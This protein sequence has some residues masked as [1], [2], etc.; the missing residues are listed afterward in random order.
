MEGHKLCQYWEFYLRVPAQQTKKK[1]AALGTFL[2]LYSYTSTIYHQGGRV[3]EEECEVTMNCSEM[4]RVTNILIG[5]FMRE[6]HACASS[7]SDDEDTSRLQEYMLQGHGGAILRLLI[8]T[9]V[10]GLSCGCDLADLLAS[11]LHWCTNFPITQPTELSLEDLPNIG[12]CFSHLNKLPTGQQNRKLSRP[13]GYSESNK[14]SRVKVINTKGG[15]V[16]QYASS[17][18][19]D[20]DDPAMEPPTDPLLSSSSLPRPS[21]QIFF[22]R[23]LSS[24]DEGEE[25]SEP[26]NE[27]IQNVSLSTNA[28]SLCTLMTRLL[29]ELV[30]CDSRSLRASNMSERLLPQIVELYV[31]LNEPMDVKC[32]PQGWTDQHVLVLKQYLLRTVF[33][34]AGCVCTLN[35]AVNTLMSCTPGGIIQT[36]LMIAQNV[37]KSHDSLLVSY[38]QDI[39]LGT[40]TIIQTSFL[41]LPCNLQC[42]SETLNL[43]KEF[44]FQHRGYNVFTSVVQALVDEIRL[45]VKSQDSQVKKRR[46]TSLIEKIG[47]IILVM[48]NIKME[49]IHSMKCSKSK[50]RKCDFSEYKNHHHDAL[51]IKNVVDGTYSD[52]YGTIDAF[53][54]FKEKSLLKQDTECAVNVIVKF[55]FNFYCAIENKCIKH[56]IIQCILKHGIC[57]CVHPNDVIGTL[58]HSIDT[59]DSNYRTQVLSLV[60]KLILEQC[61]GSDISSLTFK[62][63]AVCSH[64]TS[65]NNGSNYQSHL[66]DASD[67]ALSSSESL[68]E[69][70]DLTGTT[71]WKCIKVLQKYLTHRKES[72]GIDVSLLLLRLSMNGG[73][74]LKKQL[75]QSVYMP[76]LKLAHQT[77]SPKPET[78]TEGGP[79]HQA[80][81]QHILAGFPPLLKVLSIQQ[82]FLDMGGAE[83]LSEMVNQS[84]ISQA[85]LHILEV[86]VVVSGSDAG[87][88]HNSILNPRVSDDS[89]EIGFPDSPYEDDISD[90]GGTASSLVIC[91]VLD[92]ILGSQSPCTS[93]NIWRTCKR[94]ANMSEAFVSQF[95]Q[96]QGFDVA[97]RLLDE[98]LR[99]YID[100]DLVEDETV[101]ELGTSDKTIVGS[102]HS[103]VDNVQVDSVHPTALQPDCVQLCLLESLLG[104]VLRCAEAPVPTGLHVVEKA[105]VFSKLSAYLE[106][107][108]HQSSHN[109]KLLC[110]CLLS[111]AVASDTPSSMVNFGFTTCRKG[112]GDEGT[113]ST[114][115]ISSESESEGHTFEH[116]Y[117]ADTECT[118]SD[119]I[120]DNEFDLSKVGPPC[121]KALSQPEMCRITLE[122]VANWT[123][124][125]LYPGVAVHCLRQLVSMCKVPGNAKVLLEQKI[126]DVILG[127][128]RGALLTGSEQYTAE[129]HLLLEL[130]EILVAEQIKSK[131]VFAY[132]RLFHEKDA[133]TECLL[134]SLIN[135][136]GQQRR[137]PKHYISF[138]T[139]LA[140]VEPPQ[141]SSTS[142]F[143]RPSF[144][145]RFTNQKSKFKV[146]KVSQLSNSSSTDVLSPLV[147]APVQC[148]LEGQCHWP[149]TWVGFSAALW[150]NIQPSRKGHHDRTQKKTN[151]V[152]S[153]Y[154]ESSADSLDVADLVPKTLKLSLLREPLVPKYWNSDC[155]HVLSVGSPEK[156]FQLWVD[157]DD[158]KLTIRMSSSLFET[159]DVLC[160]TSVSGLLKENSW[161]HLTI[162]HSESIVAGRV[163]AKTNITI[164]GCFSRQLHMDHE[165]LPALRGTVDSKLFVGHSTTK[166][167][168]AEL[169][170]CKLHIGNVMLFK[171]CVITKELS[172]KLYSLGPD[173]TCISHCDSSRLNSNHAY[174][175]TKHWI[176]HSGLSLDVLC[177]VDEVSL[178]PLQ[179][180]ILLM[181]SPSMQTSFNL[182]SP[183]SEVRSPVGLS[184]VLSGKKLEFNPLAQQPVLVK[185]HLLTPL[186]A[187]VSTHITTAVNAIGGVTSLLFLFAKVVEQNRSEREQAKTLQLLFMMLRQ[188]TQYGQQFTDMSGYVL[189]AKVLQTS[190]CVVGFRLLKVLLDASCNQEVMKYDSIQN[191]WCL[192][193]NHAII[194]DTNI[195]KHLILAWKVWQRSEH[196]IWQMSFQALENLT[197]EENP[198]RE[199]NI[200]KLQF[201]D[202]VADLM[203]ICLERIQESYSAV[204]PS[205]ALSI[206]NI[207]QDLL[208]SPPDINLLVTIC[209]FLLLL[210]PA[211]CTYISHTAS[212]FYFL[213]KWSSSETKVK[214]LPQ[215]SYVSRQISKESRNRSA[216]HVPVHVVKLRN[217]Q[218]ESE[219]NE[220]GARPRSSSLPLVPH[221]EKSMQFFQSQSSD[222]DPKM[223][224]KPASDTLLPTLSKTNRQHTP[225][226]EDQKNGESFFLD[227]DDEITN[228]FS[229]VNELENVEEE[230]I[231]KDF[232]DLQN[233][234]LQKQYIDDTST[235]KGLYEDQPTL[236]NVASENSM[237]S[238]GS[239]VEAGEEGLVEITTGLLDILSSCVLNLADSMAG[240]VLGTVIRPQM[241]LVLANHTCSPIRAAVIKLLGVYLQRTNT[242]EWDSFLGYQGF[243]L[244]A[245]QL[246]Q[247]PC[248]ED[249]F[250]AC[251]SLVLGPQ[252]M[253]EFALEMMEEAPSIQQQG[254]VTILALL[255]GAVHSVEL[256]SSL[257]ETIKQLFKSS[258]V[259]AA[260]MLERGLVESLCN[261]TVAIL[262]QSQRDDWPSEAERSRLLEQIQHLFCLIALTDFKSSTYASY[263]SIRELISSLS[264]LERHLQVPLRVYVRRIQY[265]LLSYVLHYAFSRT[266][267]GLLHILSPKYLFQNPRL[268][269]LL[270]GGV[271]EKRVEDLG[272]IE[273]QDR[274]HKLA[275]L[276]IDV[277]VSSGLLGDGVDPDSDVESARIMF[278]QQCLSLLGTCVT[279]LVQ[280]VPRPLYTRSYSNGG[281]VSANMKDHLRYQLQRLLAYMLSPWETLSMRLQLVEMLVEADAT[282]FRKAMATV[283]HE[284]EL[285]MEHVCMISL[286]DN[287]RNPSNLEHPIDNYEYPL[288]DQEKFTSH[289][290]HSHSNQEKSTGNQ[291]HPL[292]NQAKQN[293]NIILQALADNGYQVPSPEMNQ[294]QNVEKDS[295]S[296]H[297][298]CAKNISI[299]Q[300]RCKAEHARACDRSEA[301]AK[302]V[303]GLAMEVTQNVTQSQNK[304]R[305]QFLDYYKRG[306]TNGLFIKKAWKNII[307]QLTHERAV[308]H[309]PESYP[310][311][312]QLDPTEGPHRVR[313]RLQRSHHTIEQRFYDEEHISKLDPE[314]HS[315]PLTF[316]LEEE[317]ESAPYSAAMISK[318]HSNE[319]ISHTASCMSVTQSSETRGEILF[320]EKT[321]YFVG[322]ETFLEGTNV[323]STPRHETWPFEDI[324]EILKRWYQLKDN[325]L[326]IFL[327][328]GNSYLLAFQ[329]TKERDAIYRCLESLD[330]PNVIRGEDFQAIHQF[331][332]RGEMTNFEYLT[333]L[334]KMAGRSFND[335]MQYPVFPFILAEYKSSTIDLKDP[336]IYRDLSKP[337]AVQ[338]KEREKR[339]I[340]NYKWLDAEYKRSAGHDEYKPP[341]Y[342]YGSHYSNSGTVLHFLVR[343][344]PFT[345]MFLSYQDNNFDIPDR[346]FH[347]M[348]TA[349]RLASYESTT[350]V[351][352]LIPE[353][354]FQPLFL[355]NTEGFNFGKRQNGLRVWDVN[356]PPWC[357]GDPR[358]FILVQ[359]QALESAHVTQMLPHWIDL[360]FGYKQQ[361][362]AAVEAINMFHPATYFGVN[363]DD[364]AD[365]VRR[366]AIR[367]MVK[368][369]GQTP[370][371]LFTSAHP[372]PVPALGDPVPNKESSSHASLSHAESTRA[373]HSQRPPVHNVEGLQWGR[374]VGSPRC[375]TPVVSW[376]KTYPT[377]M[378]TLVALHTGEVFG[379]GEN[380]TLLDIYS[381]ETGVR[382]ISNK[383]VKWAGIISWKHPDSI[384]RIK[385]HSNLPPVNFLHWD[386]DTQVTCCGCASDCR[387]L[388]FGCQSGVIVIYTT[389]FNPSKQCDI[390][391]IGPRLYLYGHS[392]A[393]TQLK[394]CKPYSILVSAS[395]DGTCI[396][397]DL[398]R[399][400][401][402]RDIRSHHN[403][404]DELALSDTLGD[405]ASVSRHGNGSCLQLHTVNAE[406]VNTT[407]T[408]QKIICLCYSN[409]DEGRSMNVIAGGLSD[410]SVVLWHSWNLS[411]IR[412]IH[413]SSLTSSITSLTFSQDC[414]RLFV[415][416]SMGTVFMWE[417]PTSGRPK[418]PNFI[419]FT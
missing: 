69:K 189:V 188:N 179:E 61:G 28:L 132:F 178:A 265:E 289:Q 1:L 130:F 152:A 25:L 78:P 118:N 151:P 107:F 383:D 55:L 110:D 182:Y 377:P 83:I 358:L 190:S 35:N 293:L 378:S 119:D 27:D 263:N 122:L 85:I 367:T 109:A 392:A 30:K 17:L 235:R 102:S 275:I 388:F 394:I 375:K 60:S 10:Q 342:H 116:G 177:G 309:Y 361:G 277:A 268:Q 217:S 131:D 306:L 341:P 88:S 364:I 381:K 75:F 414:Q 266:C 37:I 95:I 296:W 366:N 19:S 297:E 79:L 328:H 332:I 197:H 338:H 373:S 362:K 142:Q 323:Q 147:C 336:R 89:E 325:A 173:C 210:H 371:Q 14:G 183:L 195:I 353:F 169:Q 91:T 355:K 286:L 206:V 20:S 305:R 218:S 405:I 149:K 11:L 283:T 312:W 250:H 270:Q 22:Q 139:T 96:K 234:A 401:Y 153:W 42:F 333:H 319:K 403:A 6:I 140:Q 285:I 57:C 26:D 45:D 205:I 343:L 40:L 49:Y 68:S 363:V 337:M 407:Y 124:K 243:Q 398:N 18:D 115:E 99:A 240:R 97:Y 301:F 72:L 348:E 160:E 396:I 295:A 193:N 416:N 382:S 351:K 167:S 279:G 287:Q 103:Q 259:M 39:M 254:V 209:D 278:I 125:G 161:H 314:Y 404:V 67:S 230:S 376:Q 137:E 5:E 208:G 233:L 411:K 294:E 54:S 370:K 70:P 221:V 346:T 202:I 123:D 180:N 143:S 236:N 327:T 365:P 29:S 156:M 219:S 92:I 369:Y 360:V 252:H 349:W 23:Q 281:Q 308:W 330:L 12:N 33:T 136:I 207:V 106:R 415:T 93:P 194:H 384:I 284:G 214:K 81:I 368:T 104:V 34:M 390:Q 232:K 410:G 248:T 15:Q 50:H 274:F 196:V 65:P 98:T 117:D 245:S 393:V 174:L 223:L 112:S 87:K 313:C 138:P 303:S 262:E 347:S 203:H 144:L 84:S 43:I 76:T 292:S 212:K 311:T 36:L 186:V 385:N 359:R 326:E 184:R 9:G 58:L 38:S 86:L 172:M 53:G 354:F 64:H 239:R 288:S 170:Q 133:P 155:Q 56:Q 113:D 176:T 399:L 31:R 264:C 120:N 198:Y 62:Q 213:H 73:V 163:L 150:L 7:Q 134:Q 59:K 276:C 154:R 256:L 187:C 229:F 241:F 4:K 166:H 192:K 258:P 372:T 94:I 280:M 101:V 321:I 146:K 82:A 215:P 141:V 126:V 267:P 387:R 224:V 185:A 228:M 350:D 175:V 335:L 90:Q 255:E 165:I 344:P 204:H 272:Y 395:Q 44:E 251:S 158:L 145:D 108:R 291:E 13:H 157:P 329:S 52:T 159:D 227:T 339:Y 21:S 299:W 412:R 216:D 242:A 318:L 46:V 246:H 51:T 71:K 128:F 257:L 391:V 402:V 316:L 129:K 238:I 374:F 66:A 322:D 77:L 226:M 191:K 8:D 48:K 162:S 222:E 220:K 111:C 290:E 247:Y 302:T 80:V 273:L 406:H 2:K 397:W 168:H 47:D 334:N 317:A 199:F 418:P 41:Y 74:E 171:E 320:G 249:V 135:L 379:L 32:Y 225:N 307:E 409:L 298:E 244:L 164:D 271:E 310:Q 269:Q 340:E 408:E 211:M 237:S 253:D 100:R 231:T 345:Q 260:I 386:L 389:V 331:W 105:V 324:R 300:D 315:A 261:T 200:K 417:L 114:R 24:V 148:D 181:Y 352:E 380:C 3:Q 16:T 282:I 127:Q 201:A 413:V 357:G 419:S 304:E 121:V 63:C 356:L 400:S